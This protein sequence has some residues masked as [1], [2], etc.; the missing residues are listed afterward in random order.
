M[1]S[2]Y[3]SIGKNIDLII[4]QA[5]AK[6][7]WD[8]VGVAKAI[9]AWSWQSTTDVNGEMILTEAFK[10]NTYVFNY[11]TQDKIYEEVVRLS[12]DALKDLNRTD[13]NVSTLGLGRGDLVYKGDR[14]KWIK[15]VYA[16]LARNAHHLS[17]KASYNPDKVIEYVDKSFASNADNFSVPPCRNKFS[18]W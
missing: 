9:R 16:N 7:Q 12:E 11:D 5:T 15:F 10:P 14:T 6:E 8:Y 2:H 18:R 13:G 3:W 1:E 4:E 17:N